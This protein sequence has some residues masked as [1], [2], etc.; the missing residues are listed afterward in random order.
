MGQIV[1][2]AAKPKRC[3]LNQL[4]QLGTP[5]AGEHI[6]V[7]SD[8]SMNAA[9]Q[10]NFDSYIVGD[11][12]TAATALEL[13]YI[14]ETADDTP[15]AGRKNAVKGSGIQKAMSGSVIRC[16]KIENGSNG[17]SGNTS[18]VHT[19][20]FYIG[21][22]RRFRVYISRKNAENC[23]YSIGFALSSSEA[24]MGK[25]DQYSKWSGAVYKV[26]VKAD[27]DTVI[28]I[29]SQYSSAIGMS[30]TIA[31]YNGSTTNVLR[32]GDFENFDVFVFPLDIFVTREEFKGALYFGNATRTA[33]NSYTADIE[34]FSLSLKCMLSLKIDVAN[35][36]IYTA[37]LNISGTGAKQIYYNGLPATRQ[38]CW[39][40]G[41]TIF[42]YFDG[43]KYMAF[44][45]SGELKLRNG[46]PGNNANS[47]CITTSA[48][49]IDGYSEMCLVTNRPNAEGCSYR[50]GYTCSSNAELYGYLGL[51]IPNMTQKVDVSNSTKDNTC[52]CN[53]ESKLIL[54]CIGEWNDTTGAWNPI[55]V[56][57]F[58][59]YEVRIIPK[60]G[61]K[62]Q[63]LN[64][65]ENSVAGMKALIP[66]EAH[67]YKIVNGSQGNSANT[68]V[69]TLMGTDTSAI[70]V[71]PG[72]KYKLFGLS[73]QDGYTIFLRIMYYN[74]NNP[75]GIHQTDAVTRNH[76]NDIS[77]WQTIDDAI[78][79]E[80]GEYGI[81][82]QIIEQKEKS[83]SQNSPNT[84]ALRTTDFADKEMYLVDITD[85]QLVD[86]GEFNKLGSRVDALEE[87]SSNNVVAR[88][89]DKIPMLLN[90]CRYHKNSNTY[91]D[92][93]VLICTDSHAWNLANENAVTAT[94]G[95]E[96]ID[97]Y[98]HCGDIVAGSYRL[99][100]AN[101]L[102]F[103]SQID[104]LTKPGYIV[105]GNHDVGNAYYVGVSCNH[106]EAYESFIKPMVEHGWLVSGE[107]EVGKPY[108]FHDDNT[109]NIRIIGLY[110][111]DD[112]LDFNETYWKAIAY[113]SSLSNVAMNTSYTT[114]AKVNVDKY[115]SFSFE[116]VQPV[117]TPANY[118]TTPEKLP[119]YKVRRG[120]RVIRQT[121][122]QWFLD[123][124]ASTPSGFGVIVIMH[125]PF[126]DT[127]LSLDMKFSYPANVRGARFSQ[128]Q[129]ETDFIRD[130]IVAFA[131]GNSY[132]QK[133]IMKGEA[134][135]LNTLND[136][137]VSY[138]YEVAKDFSVK[139]TGAHLLG[140][141]G[142]HSH[143]DFIWKD[144]TEK[145]YQITPNC[146][147]V[148]GANDRNGDVRRTQTDGIAA[149]S[150]TVT[151]FAKGRIG[152]VKLGVNVTENGT[153][154]D[155][156]V[157]LS[158]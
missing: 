34:G 11:G 115:N 95:F 154:R 131:H 145:I 156:E 81:T 135:Y 90:M 28:E 121:Q 68:W 107:Y 32:K 52:V 60:T 67:D 42:A 133:V 62:L 85:V 130:A 140:L 134:S 39:S 132:S 70:K 114:G 13:K 43:T 138:A 80:S 136:G 111:Y 103:Q 120:D 24:D 139:N 86:M 106:E 5:A 126:S 142:G 125:N 47:T 116:C 117:T 53:E 87:E 8:N 128:N 124:L 55:R 45:I 155:F 59:G 148:D 66:S 129:M 108:W 31:E 158:E 50:Y 144:N 146:A 44:G 94:N 69:V 152:L 57:D 72:R 63:Q 15:M 113:D 88:N 153:M 109:Y 143:R 76:V 30:I 119:S 26:D 6:L 105:C 10:G 1:S 101:I 102:S 89:H 110:E 77:K 16:S 25:V 71:A 147:M 18:F 75:A 58:D 9:G 20:C 23:H 17:N 137:G 41:E 118:Y 3:N 123:T 98:V 83:L 74:T 99:E 96:S 48:V 40:D 54:F 29:P 37:T 100:S 19:E 64:E 35:S 33:P 92:Y 151:S 73:P 104:K 93:Q 49:F 61:E 79:V 14:A 21:A 7:S 84:I 91:K 2:T 150:L 22:M 127:A 157:I 122:A 36:T 82:I 12:T 97:A 78:E 149:D 56:S 112:N 46:S 27:R 38:N 141:L 65:L 51:S 4:S